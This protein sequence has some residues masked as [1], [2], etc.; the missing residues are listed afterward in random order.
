MVQIEVLGKPPFIL[1]RITNEDYYL[2]HNE[3]Q[4]NLIKMN[5]PKLSVN[6]RR[7]FASRMHH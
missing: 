6:S 2:A 1:S 3:I 7:E 5:P 4:L